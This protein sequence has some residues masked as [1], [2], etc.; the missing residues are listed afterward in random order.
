VA[1]PA[2]RTIGLQALLVCLLLLLGEAGARLASR[3]RHGEWPQSRAQTIAA[4]VRPALALYRPHAFLNTAARE[5]AQVEHAGKRVSIDP[6]GYRSAAIRSPL[7]A[8]VPRILCA[9][10]SATFDLLAPSDAE[11]WPALLESELSARGIAVEVWNGGFS[12]WTSLESLIALAVRD[13]DLRPDSIFLMQGL[14]DLQPA[15][16]RPFDPQ[17]ERGHAEVARRALGFDLPPPSPLDH[18]VLLGLLRR[19]GRPSSEPWQDLLYHD[20]A[21][22]TDAIPPEAIAVFERNLRSYLAVARAHG[23][24]VVLVTQ[25]VRIRRDQRPRDLEYAGGWLVWL[26]PAAM[27]DQLER[28]NDVTRSV[29][30]SSGA[31]L[32]DAAAAIPWEDA[33]FGD[34]FHFTPQGSRKLARFLTREAIAAGWLGAGP[35]EP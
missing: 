25:P 5:G 35:A 29:A 26:L 15:S 27:P 9:G 28:L 1:R 19:L 31:P 22:R 20:D 11:T 4:S 12:G 8:A 30:A 7:P 33:D 2:V 13:V 10:G 21:P 23:A 6:L 34:P 18:S 3:L 16:H 17:Y 32:A 14:N 24:R